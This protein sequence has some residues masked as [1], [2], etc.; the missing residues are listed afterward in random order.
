VAIGKWGL[1][2]GGEGPKS[3]PGPNWPA[4]PLNRGFDYYYGYIRHGDGHEHYPKEGLYN[5]NV[6][7][8]V[9]DDRTEVSAGLDRAYTA[10]LWTARTKKWIVDHAH[11]AP[12]QPFFIYLAY[13]TPHAVL[14]LP[15]GPYPAGGGL[16]G[17]VQ[18]LGT[19][20]HMINTAEGKI[21]SWIHP[22][23]RDATY[24]DDH[25]PKTPAKPWPDVYR[26]YATSVRRIDDGVG[27]LMQL[28]RDL[29]LD[30]NTIVVFTS[31]NGPSIESYLPAKIT[32][33]FFSSYGP[34]D[35]IKR[36][37]WEGGFRV[38]TIARW[39]ARIPA[40]TVVD[41]PSASWDW[42][43]TFADAAGL[44]APARTDGVSLL[45]ELAH[46]GQQREGVLYFE[47]LFRGRTPDFPEFEPGHRNRVRN[48]MQAIRLGDFMGVRYDV[49]SASDDFEIYNVATDP[50]EA[51]NL[52]A[53]PAEA[54]L[55]A[56]MKAEVLQRRRPDPDAPRPYDAALVPA[57]APA[58]APVA[59][60]HW[61]YYEGAQPWVPDF[62]PLK[63]AAA[64]DSARPAAD[65]RRRDG[66]FGLWF[67][68][69]VRV[70]ADGE[71][72][73][74]LR[75]S[76]G[77]VLR[78]HGATVIDA[79]YGYSAGSERSGRIRLQAG[80]HPISLSYLHGGAG[81]AALELDWTGP[82]LEKQPVPADVFFREP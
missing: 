28:L 82:G 55:Q 52:G 35:G 33:Q 11:S 30:Q 10:D 81:R 43:P 60:V 54:A 17:G 34:F 71:Y 18:W 53:E 72:T 45:P 73:F 74:T 29:H 25:D 12:N 64:G 57:S 21:D 63:P 76:T 77:A 24:D 79:D 14:E 31:D 6:G 4:H 51:R 16:S 49:K 22:D 69:Y 36:D 3:N 58:T 5:K 1:Q 13:D 9:W 41:R 70:P 50:K 62:A 32:P 65:V 59:G 66:A 40:G 80:L 42:L 78:L 46:G 38:P 37:C 67:T 44:P 20:G 26:R 19:P 27:D 68:G 15:T 47:Y 23:Y 48:Q 7:K 75:A 39:P 2:G 8:E 56:R 61:S